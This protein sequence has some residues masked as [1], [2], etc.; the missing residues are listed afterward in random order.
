MTAKDASDLLKK[1]ARFLEATKTS[2]AL[3][4]TLITLNGVAKN[5]HYIHTVDSHVRAAEFVE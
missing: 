3:F 5:S 4:T 1:K 2:K